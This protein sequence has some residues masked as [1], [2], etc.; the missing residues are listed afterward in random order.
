VL[1]VFRNNYFSFVPLDNQLNVDV[2]ENKK[3]IVNSLFKGKIIEDDEI[4][5]KLN[6]KMIYMKDYESINECFINDFVIDI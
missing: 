3:F 2:I 4:L 1:D 6:T 5:F